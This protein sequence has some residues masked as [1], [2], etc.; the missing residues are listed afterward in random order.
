MMEFFWKKGFAV[1]VDVAVAARARVVVELA[2]AAQLFAAGARDWHE[3][4]EDDAVHLDPNVDVDLVEHVLGLLLEVGGRAV[5]VLH[6]PG[7]LLA[8]RGPHGLGLALRR[9]VSLRKRN[10]VRDD[11]VCE[12]GHDKRQKSEQNRGQGNPPK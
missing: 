1:A 11:R 6:L 12:E 8:L 9:Q 4:G 10:G 3:R 2:E 5:A 7:L